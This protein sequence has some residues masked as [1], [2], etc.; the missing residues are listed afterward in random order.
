MKTVM[1]PLGK[2]KEGDKGII[3]QLVQGD[4]A[5]KL[6]EMGLLPGEKVSVEKIA[7][8]GDPISVK[9][10]SYLL[11]LRREEANVVMVQQQ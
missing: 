9:V 2:L 10:G 7:P 5:L 3:R 8:L 11:S 4:L 6:M 1:L